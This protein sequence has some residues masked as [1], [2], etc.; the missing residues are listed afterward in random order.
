MNIFVSV[1]MGW[2]EWKSWIFTF[3]DSATCELVK[4]ALERVYP[5]Y[6]GMAEQHHVLGIYHLGDGIEMFF[7]GCY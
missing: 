2:G 4:T 7:I 6:S 1:G 5:D 3:Q